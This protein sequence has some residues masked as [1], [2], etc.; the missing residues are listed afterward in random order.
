MPKNEEQGCPFC[1]VMAL[2]CGFCLIIFLWIFW[3]RDFENIFESTYFV[4]VYLP[5]VILAV[6]FFFFALVGKKWIREKYP[7]ICAI[8]LVGFWVVSGLHFIAKVSDEK[9]DKSNE[10]GD[11]F[12]SLNALFSGMALAAVA[13]T[14]ILQKEELEQNRK[15][16]AGQKN[17]LKAQNATQI[18]TRFEN[19]F[20]SLLEAQ[21]V[22]SKSIVYIGDYNKNDNNYKKASYKYQ[23]NIFEVLIENFKDNYDVDTSFNQYIFEFDGDEFINNIYEHLLKNKTSIN[24]GFNKLPWIREG[25]FDNYF[26]MTYRI[27]KFLDEFDFDKV[28]ESRIE[29]KLGEISKK[30]KISKE[31]NKIK[32]NYAGILRSQIGVFEQL[33]FF[34]NALNPKYFKCKTLIERYNMFNSLPVHMLLNHKD[35]LLYKLEAFGR[36]EQIHASHDNPRLISVY[37]IRISNEY[38]LFRFLF[39]IDLKNVQT[40]IKYSKEKMDL[41]L[42]TWQLGFFSEQSVDTEDS[43]IPGLKLKYIGNSGHSID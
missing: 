2:G 42:N 11:S 27:L 26:R 5:L 33:A 18:Q 36:D 39:E 22:I 13:F 35:V 41:L 37:R 28:A 29:F 40:S 24:E 6:T 23:K 16:L 4:F 17:E 1:G 38:A 43:T 25:R 10:I 19:S 8:I 3:V 31:V 9:T 14:I 12:G 15:E 21:R 7:W 20:F 34:Y 32:Q 30:E